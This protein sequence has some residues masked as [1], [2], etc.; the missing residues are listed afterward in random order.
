[1]EK[2]KFAV[3]AYDR[4]EDVNDQ[5]IILACNE[6]EARLKALAELG[7]D[8]SSGEKS[9][10]ECPDAVVSNAIELI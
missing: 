1:M 6:L 7:Y 8:I 4:F 9:F 3:S 10:S 5:F 2:K